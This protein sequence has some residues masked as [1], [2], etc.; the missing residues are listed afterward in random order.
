MSP[1]LLRPW[2]GRAF[3]RGR[4]DKRDAAL[5]IYYSRAQFEARQH[6]HMVTVRRWCSSLW[7]WISN[8]KC[9]FVPGQEA[10]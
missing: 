9:H 8:G 6:P 5:Q 10:M 1:I 2:E 4:P 3:S 7:K